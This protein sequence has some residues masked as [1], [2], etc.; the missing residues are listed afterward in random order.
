MRTMVIN[1]AGL[2]EDLIAEIPSLAAMGGRGA[3]LGL[4]PVLPAVTCTMQATLTT[5]EPPARH[6][7]I[8]NGLYFHDTAEV[9]FWEQSAHLVNAP[10]VWDLG[11]RIADCGLRIN[12]EKKAAPGNPKSEIRNQKCRPINCPTR[13]L[14]GME[15]LPS[16]EE[17]KDYFIPEGITSYQLMP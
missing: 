4:E 16:R 8:A 15:S 2:G 17:W 11:L 1:V 9:R 5:G 7:I 14:L 12:R 6:G 13:C 3:R 10:R